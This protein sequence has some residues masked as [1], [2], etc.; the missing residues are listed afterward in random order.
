MYRTPKHNQHTPISSLPAKLAPNQPSLRRSRPLFLPFP[1]IVLVPFL[2]FAGASRHLY[3]GGEFIVTHA[4]DA[5]V[6]GLAAV[7]FLV[8]GMLFGVDAAPTLP[9]R[10]FVLRFQTPQLLCQVV[11]RELLLAPR[12]C[13]REDKHATHGR[14]FRRPSAC[15]FASFGFAH[16]R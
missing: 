2:S 4:A 7:A 11:P 14:L 15:V 13:S 10:V 12:T 5:L 16:W 8:K 6:L 3:C 9:E 1:A